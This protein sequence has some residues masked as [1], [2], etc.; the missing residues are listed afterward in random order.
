MHMLVL[1][2]KPI[3]QLSKAEEEDSALLGHLLVVA[4]KV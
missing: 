2:R 3:T 1:P 4:A